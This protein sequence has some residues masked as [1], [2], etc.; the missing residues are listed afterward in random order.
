MSNIYIRQADVCDIPAITRIFY[1]TIQS[2]NASDYPQEELDDWS[3]W[4][5]DID[6]WAEGISEQY[7]IV[8]IIDNKIVGFSSLAK[9]GYLD[10]MFVDKDCQRHGIAKEL[11]HEIEKQ[12]KLQNN[13]IIYSDVSITATGF[14]EHYGFIVEKQQFKK[15]REKEL[16]TFRMT[17]A[18]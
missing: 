6:K 2:V 15:S 5:T 4:H 9:D 12:A 18:I 7:F 11:L 1:N 10:F 13:N 17:K 16:I 14:F 8:A 3:S